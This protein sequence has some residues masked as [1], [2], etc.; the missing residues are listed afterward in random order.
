MEPHDF[1]NLAGRAGRWGDEFQGN[2]VCINPSDQSAWPNGVPK[3]A[4]YPIKR[5]TDTVLART[6][7]L[8]DYLSNHKT[9]PEKNSKNAAKLEQVTAYLLSTFMRLGSITEADF[10][11]RHAA[12]TVH[13]FNEQ[14]SEL[15]KDIDI[16]VEMA[17]KYPGVSAIGLQRLLAA[18]RNFEGDIEELLPSPAESDDAYNLD[19][20]GCIQWVTDR[21]E[22][23]K[24]GDMVDDFE[25]HDDLLAL[26]VRY[27][28]FDLNDIPKV[29]SGEAPA[30]TASLGGLPGA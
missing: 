20:E 10:A 2:I 9:V 16:P 12:Q 19:R 6:D 17:I 22:D 28:M 30:P 23:L 7:E 15:E 25:D 26:L 18:F 3:R 14:L 24:D 11:K 4:K 27:D 5:E 21:T 29:R 13:E 1:W 8:R